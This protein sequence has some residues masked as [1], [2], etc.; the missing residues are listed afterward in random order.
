MNLHKG[1]IY[2]HRFFTLDEVEHDKDRTFLFVN[3]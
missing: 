1:T 2:M 3:K